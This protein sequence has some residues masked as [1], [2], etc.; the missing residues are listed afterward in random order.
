MAMLGIAAAMLSEVLT[1]QGPL[2]LLGVSAWR[3]LSGT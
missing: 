2:H 3:S 1:G